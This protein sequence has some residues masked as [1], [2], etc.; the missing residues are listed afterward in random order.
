MIYLNMGIGL[1]RALKSIEE[2]DELEASYGSISEDGLS[3]EREP[4]P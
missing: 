1:E 3:E 2:V 4:S